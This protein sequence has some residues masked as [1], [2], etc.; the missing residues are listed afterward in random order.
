M[1]YFQIGTLVIVGIL[2][3][4]YFINFKELF[5]LFKTK[6]KSENKDV[7]TINSKELT[8]HEIVKQWE[9]LKN[10]CDEKGLTDSSKALDSVFL[11]IIKNKKV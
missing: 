3:L 6:V 7:P 4:S 9:L 2:V 8:I 5:N 10:M 1:T 11:G